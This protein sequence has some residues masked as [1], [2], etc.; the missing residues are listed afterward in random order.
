[1]ILTNKLESQS[2]YWLSSQVKV[3]LPL[4]LTKRHT[5]KRYWGVEV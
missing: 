2:V 3:K 4:C 1:M 5:M